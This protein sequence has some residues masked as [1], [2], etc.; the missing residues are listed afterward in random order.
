MFPYTG[1]LMVIMGIFNFKAFSQIKHKLRIRNSQGNVISK[2]STHTQLLE[3][4]QINMNH[5]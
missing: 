3:D 1:L 5:F 4:L 2:P